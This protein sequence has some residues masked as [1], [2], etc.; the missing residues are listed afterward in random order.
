MKKLILIL[1][2][3]SISLPLL[4]TKKVCFVDN[5]EQADKIIT[6]VKSKEA[7]DQ[8]IYLTD[9]LHEKGKN[10]WIKVDCHS[11]EIKVYL[12]KAGEGMRVYFSKEPTDKT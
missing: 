9:E 11:S 8:I 12:S 4:A 5:K 10:V 3:G 7:A 2:A 6:I 1:L